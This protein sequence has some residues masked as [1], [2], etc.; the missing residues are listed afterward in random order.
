M[1]VRLGSRDGE[2]LRFKYLHGRSS[3]SAKLKS[4][5]Y[6][7]MLP[8]RYRRGKYRDNKDYYPCLLVREFFLV[9]IGKQCGLNMTRADNFTSSR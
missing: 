6:V 8:E 7:I 9:C 3:D 2:F 4:P 1:P 5:H